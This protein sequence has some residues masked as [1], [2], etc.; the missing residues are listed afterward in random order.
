MATSPPLSQATGYG[1]IVG[2]GFLFAFGMMLTTFVLKRYNNELQTSEVFS[3]AG[4]TVKSGLVSSAVVSSWTWAATLLQSSSIAYQYGVSGPFWYASGATVQIILFAT[5]AIE[6][7]CKAPN[8][9]TF[10]EA[11]RARYGPVTHGV[12]I[13]FGLMTNILV[14]AMLLTGGSAVATSLCGVPTAAGCFLLPVGVVLYTMFGGIKATFLTDY[15]H[16]VV[17]LVIILTFAFTA[18]ATGSQLG[19]PSAVYDLL[20]EATERHPVEGNAGGSYLTMRSKEG[21]IFFVINIVGN[22]GTVFMDN[23]YYNKAIAASPVHALPGYI[24]GGLSW[25]AIPWLA[26][27]TMGLSALALENNPVFPTYPNRMDPADVSAGL[28]LPNAAVALLGSG[29]AAATL[30]LIFMAVTSAMSAELIAVSSIW[31]YDIYKTY[32]NPNASGRRLIYMSHTSCAVYA[33]CMAAFSTGLHYAGISMGYLYLLMG[34]IISGAV[35]PSTLTL[36]WSRQSWAAATF[37]PPLALCCSVTGWLVQAKVQYGELSVTTTGSN[38]PM[39]VGNVVSLLAPAIF[40]PIL[41]LVFRTPAYDW[42]SMAQIRKGD[43]SDLAAAAQVDLE[44]IPGEHSK[45]QEEE[46][47][48]QSK[49]LRASKIARWLTVAMTL[50]FLILWPMPMYGSSYIFSKKF[51]TGWVVV[52]ILW[53]FCSSF[54]VG[55]YPLWEGR[56]T[57]VRTVKAIFK[58]ITGRGNPH[59]HHGQPVF[60]EEDESEKEHSKKTSTPPQVEVEN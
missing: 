27:T 54:C 6:L 10:L 18:Y 51:F 40:V 14:T 47:A 41:S 28:V 60:R 55:L 49:L 13:V 7:K 11:I 25:F 44:M 12:Y 5:I 34:V 23:G 26:A 21:V 42:V 37:A 8:A 52:G 33:L 53:L 39:L 3:T 9:H 30:L 46:A 38:Y 43:D 4:R 45:R 35:L 58:D 57:S 17:I 22:F 36:L 20:M 15:I 56:K 24:A 48:E 31:T 1:V 29:G 32:I 59:V 50:S 2:L 19:S 16:T